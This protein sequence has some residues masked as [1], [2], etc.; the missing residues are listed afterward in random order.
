MSP[1]EYDEMP[2]NIE[3]LFA[4]PEPQRNPDDNLGTEDLLEGA[5]LPAILLS[6]A[7]WLERNASSKAFALS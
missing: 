2:E 3:D 5:S 4:A 6:S 7:E 1:A